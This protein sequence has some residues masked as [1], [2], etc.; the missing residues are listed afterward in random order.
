MREKG[1]IIVTN[2]H[3]SSIPNAQTL[4]RRKVRIET[5]VTVW[6]PC[7]CHSQHKPEVSFNR[8]NLLCSVFPKQLHFEKAFN[9][10]IFH[11]I[12]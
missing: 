2:S 5:K 11:F 8:E 3:N 4:G 9:L 10:S 12:F 1:Q 6:R 7:F